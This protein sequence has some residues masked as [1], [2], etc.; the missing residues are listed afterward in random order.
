M[1]A[2]PT[3]RNT[4]VKSTDTFV[5]DARNHPHAQFSQ[6]VEAFA[7]KHKN[8]SLHNLKVTKIPYIEEKELRIKSYSSSQIIETPVSAGADVSK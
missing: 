1:R 7:S 8:K 2:S 3:L 4:L 5:E 6:V